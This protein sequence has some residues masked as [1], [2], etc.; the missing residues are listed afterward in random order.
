MSHCN[1]LTGLQTSCKK[2]ARRKWRFSTQVPFRT[3]IISK[4]SDV[5]LSDHSFPR[6]S[7]QP[8]TNFQQF[9]TGRQ[10][11]HKTS[12]RSFPNRLRTC[13]ISFRPTGKKPKQ[14]RTVVFVS[15][16]LRRRRCMLAFTSDDQ[17]RFP[18]TLKTC[19]SSPQHRTCHSVLS[20][21]RLV[22]PTGNMSK[23]LQSE[24][25]FLRMR[26]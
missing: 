24:V 11:E 25:I 13:D 5:K 4:H 15:V 20:C 26:Q 22:K 6:N 10:L 2:Y 18:R 8:E 12:V 1:P 3:S 16:K 7:T 23:A 21:L 17:T 19:L 14:P 9:F